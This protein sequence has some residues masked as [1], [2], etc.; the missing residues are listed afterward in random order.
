MDIEQSLKFGGTWL[1]N[2]RLYGHHDCQVF[3][4]VS[5]LE[6]LL[7]MYYGKLKLGSKKERACDTRK[8]G[9]K[10]ERKCREISEWKLINQSKLKMSSV[11]SDRV[12]S[13]RKWIPLNQWLRTWEIEAICQKKLFLTCN[14][15]LTKA[16]LSSVQKWAEC[17]CPC[18]HK[19]VSQNSK[20]MYKIGLGNQCRN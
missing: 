6:V 4:D 16:A 20:E 2:L 12:T 7:R 18:R 10:S 8:T 1:L 13:R 14:P 19:H 9:A 15:S 11:D 3:P 5:F 17:T